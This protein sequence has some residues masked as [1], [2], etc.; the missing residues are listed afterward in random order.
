MGPVVIVMF[1]KNNKL[2]IFFMHWITSQF[3]VS[4]QQRMNALMDGRVH[5]AI[6][7]SLTIVMSFRFLATI[8]SIGRDRSAHHKEVG[9]NK[10]SESTMIC[11]KLKV[12]KYTSVV[13][14]KIDVIHSYFSRERIHLPDWGWG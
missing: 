10:Y 12:V 2:Y 4:I 8:L 7:D 5:V 1:T 14:I 13:P 11:S 6:L 9:G 3:V